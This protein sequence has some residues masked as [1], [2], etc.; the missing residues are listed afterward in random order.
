MS[1]PNLKAMLRPATAE[2]AMI[3]QTFRRLAR[4][5]RWPEPHFANVDDDVLYE[6]L[7]LAAMSAEVE[8][9]MADRRVADHFDGAVKAMGSF[10]GAPRK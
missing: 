10:F 6:N 4:Q 1:M 9:R 3:R 2:A 8:A 7:N 5:N